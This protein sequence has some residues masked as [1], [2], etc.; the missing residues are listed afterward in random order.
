MRIKAWRGSCHTDT[1]A[2]VGEFLYEE[3]MRDTYRQVVKI[4]SGIATE[5]RE[6]NI[7]RIDY[8][9]LPVLKEITLFAGLRK[10]IMKTVNDGRACLSTIHGETSSQSLYAY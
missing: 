3:Q 6:R 10:L 9:Q 4:L 2:N 1:M 7:R 8:V 5:W